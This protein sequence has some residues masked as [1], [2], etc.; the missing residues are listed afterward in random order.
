MERGPLR[1]KGSGGAPGAGKRRKKKK[2]AKGKA[3]IVSSK[4]QEEEKQHG[5]D[6]RTPA[7][8]AFEK[9][10]EKRQMERIL[11]KA[12]KTHKQRVEDFNRHLDTLSEHY[13]I[14]KVSWT[15]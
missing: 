10:Q 13:D 2:K 11:K 12:S 4:K 15:K 1:L 3:Q 6:K 9:M 7:Q 8:V 14:P 5:L